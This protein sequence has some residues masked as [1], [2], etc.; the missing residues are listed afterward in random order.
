MSKKEILY[1]ILFAV[2]VIGIAMFITTFV[3]Q[4]VV[5]DGSSM[6]PTLSDGDTMFVNKFVYRFNDP[7]RFDIVVF[8]NPNEPKMFLIK[9]IIGLPGDTVNISDGKV[10]V[11][12]EVLDES[13]GLEPINDAGIALEDI[14]IPTEEYF[15]LG[16]N[17]NN[18]LDSRN[19]SIGL[20]KKDNIVGR[21]K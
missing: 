9:R 15:V 19:M 20:I 5:V 16:D 11:N 8:P 13:Y 4:R 21:V 10:Y 7:E 6:E 14:C 18:S 2:V 1:E 12:G 17:R 3:M